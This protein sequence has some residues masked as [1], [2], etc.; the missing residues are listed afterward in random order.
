LYFREENNEF[1]QHE[2]KAGNPCLDFIDFKTNNVYRRY[3]Y[4][5]D[6]LNQTQGM[7][8][9]FSINLKPIDNVLLIQRT[10]TENP[11]FITNEQILFYILG[12]MN[13]NKKNMSFIILEVDNLDDY[14]FESEIEHFHEWGEKSEGA[15]K[16]YEYDDGENNS[17]RTPV[18]DNFRARFLIDYAYLANYGFVFSDNAGIKFDINNFRELIGI[19]KISEI[20]N[21]NFNFGINHIVKYGSSLPNT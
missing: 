20:L 8:K 4:R 6:D 17:V 18:F 16:I 3:S 10:D 2:F 7:M 9:K 11:S 21:I 5:C 12:N 13:L 15:C 14:I 1:S 19:K